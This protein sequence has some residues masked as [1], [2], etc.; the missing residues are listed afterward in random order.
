MLFDFL[1]LV[2][3]FLPTWEVGMTDMIFIGWPWNSTKPWGW[4]FYWYSRY[5]HG[6]GNTVCCDRIVLLDNALQADVSL[7]F[8]ASGGYLLH[9]WCRGAYHFI[10][11]S[12]IVFNWLICFQKTKM[13]KWMYHNLLWNYGFSFRRTLSWDTSIFSVMCNFGH[14]R[15]S[16]NW[17]KSFMVILEWPSVMVCVY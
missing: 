6:I 7:V 13:P 1:W 14:A 16:T 3:W 17:P 5:Q 2:T 9:R 8:G 10:F 15:T 11:L 12:G 4:R